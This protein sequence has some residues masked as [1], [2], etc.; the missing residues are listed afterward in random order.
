[1][2][3]STS[4]DLIRRLAD[5]IDLWLECYGPPS[6]LPLEQDDTYNLVQEA[7]SFLT[8]D[9]EHK[10]LNNKKVFVFKTKKKSKDGRNYLLAIPEDQITEIKS[11]VGGQL[12][13][14][15]VNGQEVSGSF[16]ELVESLG[17]RID[18]R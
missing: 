16:E 3:N 18:V 14:L 13:Y 12:V 8:Q 5:D 7:R 1:M 4:Q 17:H 11:I 10:K 15:V 9:K 6:K 2:S